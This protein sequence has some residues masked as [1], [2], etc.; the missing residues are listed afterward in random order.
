MTKFY[1][2]SIVIHF[3]II[4][5]GIK[6]LTPQEL[7][8]VEK[9][10]IIVSVQNQRAISSSQKVNTNK[11]LNEEVEKKEVEKKETKKEKV[12]KKVKTEELKTKKNIKKQEI[13]KEVK[14]ESKVYNEFED[15]NR[16]IRGRDGVFTAVSSEGVEF[17]IIKEIDPNYPIRA[18]KIGYKGSGNIKVKF[19]VDL[20]GEVSEIVFLAGEMG[21]GFKEEVEKALKYWK[22]KPIKY[23]GKG[24]KVYFEKEFKFRVR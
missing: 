17:E 9:K 21:Y 24:I 2:F 22:F 15:K 12:F 10:N 1:L 3:I 5:I 7:K 13:I 4:G 11:K 23:K 16:F 8:F 20:N 14:K 18:K 6:N 19:L